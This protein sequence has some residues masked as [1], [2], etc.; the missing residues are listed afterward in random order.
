[1]ENWL[2][3]MQ[4]HVHVTLGGC[5][6]QLNKKKWVIIVQ[7]VVIEEFLRSLQGICQDSL[8][9]LLED[10]L[11]DGVGRGG[12]Y[13]WGVWEPSGLGA[14]HIFDSELAAPGWVGSPRKNN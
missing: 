9:K 13:P 5:W 3:A 8:R 4:E 14:R 6:S 12:S 7:A 2:M 1:M 11:R 10:S